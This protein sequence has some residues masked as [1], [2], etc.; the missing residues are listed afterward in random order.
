MPTPARRGLAPAGGVLGPT[1]PM[2][3][4]APG[5][6]ILWSRREAAAQRDGAQPSAKPV[7]CSAFLGPTTRTSWPAE[8]WKMPETPPGFGASPAG[9]GP[10]HHTVDT[11]STA[12]PLRHSAYPGSSRANLPESPELSGYRMR[13][14]QRR[15]TLARPET[16]QRSLGRDKEVEL[17]FPL[18]RDQF[19]L[20]VDHDPLKGRARGR[21][22][23]D[24]AK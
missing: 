8:L 24:V 22:P 1:V 5:P 11:E 17:V 15:E 7:G 12:G 19:A 9:H 13:D 6:P 20:G 14:R 4:S 21:G 2:G 23:G 18:L 10:S 16:S 3:S